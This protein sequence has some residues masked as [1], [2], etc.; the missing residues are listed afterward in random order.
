MK[1]VGTVICSALMAV[2]SAW[3]AG[4]P[5]AAPN[6]IEMPAHYRNWRVLG[7]SHREDNQSL[8]VIVGNDT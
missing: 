5:P 3:A 8:R 7:V 6:G 2:H 4:N 1:I